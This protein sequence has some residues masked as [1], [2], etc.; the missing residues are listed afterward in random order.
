MPSSQVVLC[1]E[2][3]YNSDCLEVVWYMT[4]CFGRRILELRRYPR[5][6]IRFQVETVRSFPHTLFGFEQYNLSKTNRD[7]NPY[8][9][10]W[11]IL[12]TQHVELRG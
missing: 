5:V 4:S 3:G 9:A 8:L 11:N 1:F 12:P 6:M 2:N 10:R 7:N